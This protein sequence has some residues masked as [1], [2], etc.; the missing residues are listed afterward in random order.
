M[1]K[2]RLEST[3]GNKVSKSYRSLI[4]ILAVILLALWGARSAGCQNQVTSGAGVLRV[5]SGGAYVV[6]AVSSEALD[7]MIN[8]GSDRGIAALVLG[9]EGFVVPQGTQVSIIGSGG[10]GK[11]KIVITDGEMTGRIGVVPMEWVVAR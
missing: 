9:G 1:I 8:A 7:E 11:K 4:I 2:S 6:V 10:F 3:G 5:P